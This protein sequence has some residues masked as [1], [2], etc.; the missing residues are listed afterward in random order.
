M[1]LYAPFSD[2]AFVTRVLLKGNLARQFQIQCH[3]P[4]PMSHQQKNQLRQL[5]SLRPDRWWSLTTKNTISKDWVGL[6]QKPTSLSYHGLLSLL[7]FSRFTFMNQYFLGVHHWQIIFLHPN[8]PLF[9]K[10]TW[11]KPLWLQDG[12]LQPC[13]LGISEALP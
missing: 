12:A 6:L 8:S 3:G 7:S 11:S 5:S 10:K 2:P 13:R 4:Q 1:P 9:G